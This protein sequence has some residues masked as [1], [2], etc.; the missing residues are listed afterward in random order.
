MT[1]PPRSGPGPSDPSDPPSPGGQGPERT[2]DGPVLARLVTFL[3]RTS[4]LV[5]VT[6]AHGSVVYLNRAARTRLGIRDDRRSITTEDLFPQEAFAVY[7]DQ[8]RPRIVG[9]DVWTGYL[10]IRGAVEPLEMWATIVGEATPD[11]EVEWLVLAARDVNDW[12]HSPDAVNRHAA[13]DEL[14][15]L[16]TRSL[17][18]DHLAKARSRAT[19]SGQDVAVAFIDLD[20][21]TAVNHTFGST[22]GDGVLVEVAHRLRDSVRVID[23]VARVGGDQFVVLFDGVADEDEAAALTTQIQATLESAT[24]DVEDRAINV[25]A[26]IGIVL[27]RDGELGDQLLGRADTAMYEVKADRR[28]RRGTPLRIGA[29]LRSVT[30][31]DVAVAVT[32]HEIVPYYQRVVDVG[33][34]STRGAH[35]LA[36]WLRPDGSAVDASAF[37]G[38]ADDSGVSFTLDLAILRHALTD[39]AARTDLGRLYVPVSPRFLRHPGVE[40]FVHEVL[41]RAGVTADRLAVLVDERLV[42]TRA[43]VIGDA[44]SALRDLGVHLVLDT[45]PPGDEATVAPD[46]RPRAGGMAGLF[47]QVRLRPAWMS[48][49]DAHP[50]HIAELIAQ[51]HAAD[52]EVVVGGVETPAQLGRLRELGCDLAS[53]HLIGRPQ[54][55]PG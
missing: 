19:R 54:P 4:D 17:L 11:G 32:R 39:L 34:G 28:N 20:D 25:S 42:T 24:V 41:A 21:M 10:P 36:R 47:D 8:I 48:E 51:A 44:I 12:H 46:R 52:Q 55:D 31:K 18:M 26:S 49:L 1:T 45:A 3:D 16:A 7:F 35:A 6:D 50:D 29:E 22:V 43:L 13:F 38:I 5:G 15:G 30:L 23:T 53:G 33:D 9:G 40:R 27:S 14:T 2:I 37:L